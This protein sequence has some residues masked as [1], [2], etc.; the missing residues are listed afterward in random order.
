MDNFVPKQKLKQISKLLLQ[1]GKDFL[2]DSGPQWAAA[3]S[4]YTLLS[5]FPLMLAAVAISAYFIDPEWTIQQGTRLLGDFLPSGEE[6]IRQ[7]VE[8]MIQIRGGVSFFSILAL[9]WSGSRVFGVVTKALNTAYDV[10]ELYG[11][12]KRT[13]IELG[14]TLSIGL[15]LTLALSSRVLISLARKLTPSSSLQNSGVWLALEYAILPAILLISVFL[16]YRYVPRRRVK[17][18]AALMGA[19]FFTVLYFIARPL[20]TGYLQAFA[21]YNLIY[22]PLTIVIILV[23][24]AWVVANLLLLGGELASHIQDMWIEQK[25]EAQVEEAH[26]RRDPNNSRMD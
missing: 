7:I 21:N 25:S 5:I 26:K 9:T 1:S 18:W 10:D 4:Y 2:N 19:V 14:M 15:L 3:I 22:G 11:F 8:N 17:W 13:L 6:R 20:F 12:L 16:I 23:L 24:W